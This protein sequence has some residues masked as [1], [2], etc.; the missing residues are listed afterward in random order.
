MS[1]AQRL[2]AI[3]ICALACGLGGVVE[4][5]AGIIVSTPA[6]LHPGDHFRFVFV[7]DAT[8]TAGSAA[9]SDYNT[10]VNND[11][12]A[13][14]GAGGVTYGGIN[15]S[16]QAIVSTS[17]MSAATNIGSTG[18][19]VWLVGGPEIATSDGAT[20]L[21]SGNSILS[22]IDKDL[23][24]V[25]QSNPVWTGTNTHGGQAFVSPLGLGS[26]TIGFSS[27]SNSSWV[28]MNHDANSNS[29]PLYGIS[30]DL[31]VPAAQS[32]V[33]PE[34]STFAL[35]LAGILCAVG[36]YRFRRRRA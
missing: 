14:A 10:F 8:T 1:K 33:V 3:N 26:P 13:E 2:L 18:A 25:V 5:E 4:S 29:H 32:P 16:W 28:Q 27:A 9:I 24:Q 7:T 20:G 35:M 15:L 19:S 6:G 31:Q 11:A 12:A 30:Q 23:K 34:P 22:A 21:W 17:A 36:Y